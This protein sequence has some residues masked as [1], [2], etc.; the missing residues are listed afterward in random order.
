M[1]VFAEEFLTGVDP[2]WTLT[3]IGVMGV[4]AITVAVINAVQYEEPGGRPKD[5]EK[6][7]G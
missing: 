4:I 3:I 2:E 6:D 1:I 5:E 7:D